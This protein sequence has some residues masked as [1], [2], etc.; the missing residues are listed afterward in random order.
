MRAFISFRQI[1]ANVLNQPRGSGSLIRKWQTSPNQPT[2]EVTTL[3]GQFVTNHESQIVHAGHCSELIN[4]PLGYYSADNV[5]PQ[6]IS[7][8]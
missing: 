3:S 1:Y 2:V 4:V 8:Q 5:P 7:H 6:D